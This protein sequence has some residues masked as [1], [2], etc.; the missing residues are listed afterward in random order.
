MIKKY[1]FSEDF[2]SFLVL[3]W[4]EVGEHKKWK[5]MMAAY[6]SEFLGG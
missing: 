4:E 6:T 5:M 2:G 1:D 3:V